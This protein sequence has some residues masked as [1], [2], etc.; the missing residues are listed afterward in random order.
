M[1]R[2]VV[3]QLSVQHVRQL[4]AFEAKELVGMFGMVTGVMPMF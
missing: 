2:H 3:D 4:A 1:G